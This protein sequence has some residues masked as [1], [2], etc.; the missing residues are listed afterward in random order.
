[1]TAEPMSV[2][3]TLTNEYWDGRPNTRNNEFADY[4]LRNGALMHR[5]LQRIA[6]VEFPERLALPADRPIVF[7][8]NHRSFLDIAVA[9][10]LF[11]HVQMSCRFQVQARMFDLPVIGSWLHR[12][13]CIP[14][15]TKTREQAEQTSIDALEAGHTVAVMPEG[16]LVPPSERPNGVGPGRPGIGRIVE[17]TGALVVPVACYGTDTVW[18]RGRPVP[19]LG[20]LRRRVVSVDFGTPIEFTGTDHQAD[21]DRLMATIADMLVV[22]ATRYEPSTAA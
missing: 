16:R 22:Q 17:R 3:P 13:G 1:M 10:A 12:L 2:E 4:F 6:T 8:A 7:A 21:V 9:E 18:P 14:T 11:A 15:N 5:L 19:R 20:L